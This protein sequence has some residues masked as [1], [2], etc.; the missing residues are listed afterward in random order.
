MRLLLVRHLP[1][2]DGAG[3]CYGRLDLPAR[4][5]T[6]AELA[7]MRQ[8][9]SCL[10]RPILLSSPARRCRDLARH[11]GPAPRLEPRLRELDFGAWEGLPWDAVPRAA[12]DA[13][14]ADPAGFTPPGGEGM[15]DFLARLGAL[16][17]TLCEA[18]R[19]AVLVTHGGPMRVLPALLRGVAPDLLAPAPGF[20]T[21]LRV[22]L[23][24]A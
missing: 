4:A 12:L 14:A 2:P 20:G 3:R 18:G 15:A 23:P 8:E 16:A 24:G 22:E 9:I 6:A 10:R 11:L 7:A 21:T 17:E 1:V 13:W 5:A 19:D